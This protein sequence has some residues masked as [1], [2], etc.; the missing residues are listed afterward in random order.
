[1]DR[2]TVIFFDS[3][4][5]AAT[6]S[7]TDRNVLRGAL[8]AAGEP[9]VRTT[10]YGPGLR[11]AGRILSSSPLPRHELVIVSDFQRA[12]WDTDGGETAS[13]RLP[14]GTEVIPISVADAEVEA[15]VTV[16]GAEFDRTIV[17]ERERVTIAARLTSGEPVSEPL[18]VTL[19]V[20]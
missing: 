2:G 11:Y 7:T 15:N 20:D 10:R 6:E 13:L 12:G 18:P 8:R 16:T 19:E 9:G 14:A 5:E 4:A 1:G 17:A 3:G